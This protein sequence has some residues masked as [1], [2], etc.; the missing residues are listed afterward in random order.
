MYNTFLYDFLFKNE[1][2]AY[3]QIFP[4]LGCSDRYP[5]YY[6]SHVNDGKQAVIALGDFTYDG[7]SM[8][9]KSFNLSLN[10]IL[11]AG[12]YFTK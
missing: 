5:K 1:I 12:A 2:N 9:A 11:V 6:Y 8:S 10:H 4:S 7:W 3:E